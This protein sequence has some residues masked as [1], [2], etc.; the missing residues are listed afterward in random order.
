[1][2]PSADLL[3]N[4]TKLQKVGRMTKIKKNNFAIQAVFTTFAVLNKRNMKKK[5]NHNLLLA[6]CVAALAVLC[7]LSIVL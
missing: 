7:V 1:L 5:L 3:F 6:L 2:K 4:A